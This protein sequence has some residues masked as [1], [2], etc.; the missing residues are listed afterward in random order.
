V[1]AAP[2]PI[3]MVTIRAF[4]RQLAVPAET[5]RRQTIN[6]HRQCQA[7]TC[8][9]D[10]VAEPEHKLWLFRPSRGQWCV[11]LSRLR[12]EHPERYA[13]PNLAEVTDRQDAMEAELKMLR[14]RYNALAAAFREHGQKHKENDHG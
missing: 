2:L 6:L 5:C 8:G 13:G 11:N 14:K 4:A 12:V 10:R 3:R 9:A 7:G 1:T